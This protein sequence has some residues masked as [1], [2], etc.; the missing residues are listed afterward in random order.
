MLSLGRNSGEK[1]QRRK[2][3]AT[4]FTNFTNFLRLQTVDVV[5]E[6]DARWHQQPPLFS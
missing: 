2:H 5:G 6:H 1:N 4:N 3:F